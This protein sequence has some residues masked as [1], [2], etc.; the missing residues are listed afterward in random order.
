MLSQGSVPSPALDSRKS[1]RTAAV[2]VMSIFQS[3]QTCNTAFANYS[4]AVFDKVENPLYENLHG[5][6]KVWREYSGASE[7]DGVRLDNRLSDFPQVVELF[8][9]LLKIISRGLDDGKSRASYNASG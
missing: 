6:F 9:D 4:A 3:T 2:I 7:R 1:S 8:V 5:R